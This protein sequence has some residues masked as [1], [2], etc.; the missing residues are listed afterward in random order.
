LKRFQITLL[1][2]TILV[3]AL[4]LAALTQELKA[5]ATETRPARAVTIRQEKE[6]RVVDQ[7]FYAGGSPGIP[8]APDFPGLRP[9]GWEPAPKLPSSPAIGSQNILVVLVDFADKPGTTDVNH[10][11]TVVFGDS[12]GSLKHYIGETS[13]SKFTLNGTVGGLRW[14][15][16]SK[17][18]SFW[19]KDSD[20]GHDDAN[21]YIFE[22]AREVL[23]MVDAQ[24]DFRAFDVNHDNVLESREL[25]VFVVHSGSGQ[26]AYPWEAS[27]IW[28][29][30]GYI[31]GQ[32]YQGKDGSPLA[33]TF[34]D[35][36]RVSKHLNDEVGGYCMVAEY[37]PLG[38]YAHEF[39]H[40]LGLPDLYSEFGGDEFLDKWD[41]MAKGNWNGN[42]PGSS[43][44][45]PSSWSK[46]K[47]G[48][49]D[50]EVAT[51]TSGETTQTID[52]LEIPTSG[53]LALRIP[54][55]TNY[56]L[57]EVRQR[58]LYDSGLPD[59]GVLILLCNDS[60]ESGM[61]PVRLV[62]A[63]STVPG[64]DDAPFDVGENQTF[65]D[66]VYRVFVKVL[67]AEGSSY[68]VKA[69]YDANI[70]R[71]TTSPI[72]LKVEVNGTVYQAP[73]LFIWQ[74]GLTYVIK[75]LSPQGLDATTRYAF[76]GWSDGGNQTHEVKAT[77][78]SM[79][80]TANY[81][82]QYYLSI[83]SPFGTPSGKGWYDNGTIAYSSI[84]PIT[85]ETGSG[86]RY[87]FSHWAG[88]ASGS[89][90]SRSDAIVM[91]SPKFVTAEWK[92]QYQV[93]LAFATK[94]GKNSIFPSLCRIQGANPNGTL[95]TVQGYSPLWLDDVNWTLR[96]VLWMGTDVTPNAT[97]SYSPHVL[98]TWEI[99]CEVLMVSF[100]EI[101]KDA[102]G[103]T[104][105]GDLLRFELSAPN[106]TLLTGLSTSS[107]LLQTGQ[108][109]VRN[110]TWRGVDVTQ[111]FSTFNS[112]DGAPSVYCS[113]YNLEVQVRDILGL[114]ASATVTVRHIGDSTPTFS[115]ETSL[116]GITLTQLPKATYVV[117]ASALGAKDSKTIELTKSTAVKLEVGLSYSTIGLGAFSGIVVFAVV[118]WILKRH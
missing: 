31:Y 6:L 105:V 54:V 82:V 69:S 80:L 103:G 99:P 48:W 47:L 14:Y 107:Y 37:S 15:R 61:G 71:I 29:H 34:L 81:V 72:L 97:L 93:L 86:A 56:Y 22:L 57:V 11:Q 88:D 17:D 87:R 90:H 70:V 114:P 85:V 36:V 100:A 117:E 33:D 23:T 78:S 12:S 39:G 3:L 102:S 73:Q 59:K 108:F 60:R 46:L 65:Y 4:S 9:S 89:N 77:A 42:P 113:V 106:D 96:Q 79:T 68:S 55:G 50:R 21:A 49:I 19:A 116:G 109:Q 76:K 112:G 18:M 25:S 41:L 16:S 101:F 53:L 91:T 115:G 51:L 66:P 13:Y 1:F 67:S 28:S 30:F 45:H 5:V 74:I 118:V 98:G 7:E 58:T 2:V 110:V 44:A 10:F 62:D 64:L 63:Q 32:G 95:I 75:A 26:E 24:V 111:S 40:A 83:T 27:D 38:T 20:D 52:R 84:T 43:P 94:D 104:L 35:G 8:A 92:L